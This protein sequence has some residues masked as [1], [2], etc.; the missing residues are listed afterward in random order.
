MSTYFLSVMRRRKKKKTI[1]V[2]TFSDLS[3]LINSI[4]IDSQKEFDAFLFVFCLCLLI[5]DD[6][7]QWI[8]TSLIFL[9]P[10][11]QFIILIDHH[12]QGQFLAAQQDQSRISS[13]SSP[14]F[15]P[16]SSS[17]YH[18]FLNDRSVDRAK[19]SVAI[20]GWN[21]ENKVEISVISRSFFLTR[22]F[23]S[24][25]HFHSSRAA[26]FNFMQ[27]NS[28]CP[29]YLSLFLFLFFSHFYRYFHLCKVEENERTGELC[30][31]DHWPHHY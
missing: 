14:S 23:F 30:L 29:V 1:L 25:F 3:A 20:H 24:Y 13:S 16:S 12:V 4:L 7:W 17:N 28:F 27:V 6:M 18:H 31:F 21:I 9:S 10:S 15:L 2:N 11:F 19:L 5:K 22:S 8:W 26:R